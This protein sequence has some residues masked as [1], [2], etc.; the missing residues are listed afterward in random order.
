MISEKRYTADV[1]VEKVKF[2]LSELTGISDINGIKFTPGDEKGDVVFPCFVFAKSMKK[3]PAV[4]SAEICEQIKEKGLD[5]IFSDV[6]NTGGYLN[7]FL[8]MKKFNSAVVSDF[9]KFQDKYGSLSKGEGKTIVIDYS[10]PNIAKPFSVGHLRSTNIG[11]SL[12]KILRFAGYNVIGDNHLGDWGTQFGK[13]IYAYKNWGDPKVIEKDPIKELLNLYVRFHEEAG[14]NSDEH[15]EEDNELEEKAR[16]YFKQLEDG[17][18]EITKIWKWM[19]DISLKDFD[20]VYKILNVSFEEMLGESFYNDKMEEIKE[21]A[22]EK[23]LLETDE[24]GVKLIRLDKFGISTPLLLQKKDGASLYATRDLSGILYRKRTWNPEAILYV[25]GEEQTLYFKQL[26]KAAEL[27]GLDSNCVHIAFGLMI[28]PAEGKFSTRKGRV[29]FLE[30]VLKDAVDRARKMIEDRDFSEEKKQ[31]IAQKVG[32][33]AVKYNDLSQSRV[34][35]VGFDWD[36]M[37]SMDGNSSPYLQYSYSRAKAVLRKAEY[38]GDRTWNDSVELEKDE[39]QLLNRLSQFHYIVESSAVQYF[40]H[41][42]ANWLYDLARDFTS[43]YTNVRI[44]SSEEPFR[45]NRL[46]LTD[47]YSSVIKTGLSLLGIETSE[48]M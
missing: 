20:K 41:I 31:E 34:K 27:L 1:V 3:N 24:D 14:L 9:V 4:I 39:K 32:I 19:R 38:N 2:I 15:P 48:E 40:P 30:D 6:K 47:F 25:V 13:L 29:I 18:P 28:L 17:D 36:K 46:I 42:I 7:F 23:G 21:I 8:D 10:S 22:E 11:S 12:S 33:G 16:A 35:T 5:D 37:L 45:Q 44:V 43:F 26:I